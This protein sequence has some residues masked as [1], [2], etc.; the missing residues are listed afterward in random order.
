MQAVRFPGENRDMTVD[1]GQGACFVEVVLLEGKRTT[2]ST[3]NV[4]AACSA[5]QCASM[6]AAV[7]RANPS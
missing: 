5:I 7:G 3:E 4:S 2:A 1:V 6:L